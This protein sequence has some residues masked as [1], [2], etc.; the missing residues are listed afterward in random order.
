MWWCGSQSVLC[1][2]CGEWCAVACDTV[3]VICSMGYGVRVAFGV[4]RVFRCYNVWRVVKYGI[5]YEYVWYVVLCVTA[6]FIA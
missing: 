4:W 1:V 3:P 6:C 5:M 2:V